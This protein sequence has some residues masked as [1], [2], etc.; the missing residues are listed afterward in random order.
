MGLGLR[1]W[2]WGC[3]ALGLFV[4]SLA[5][6]ALAAAEAEGN[7]WSRLFGLSNAQPP[8]AV[9]APGVAGASFGLG[10]DIFSERQ[11][12]LR[13]NFM[14]QGIRSRDLL[15]GAEQGEVV[16]TDPG[17]LNRK[18]NFRFDL[19]GA[20]VQP[21]AALRLPPALG[22]YPTLVLQAAAADVGLDFLDRNRPGDSSSLGGRGPLFGAGLDL[23]RALCQG[24]PWFA[25]ASYLFQRLPSLTVDRSPRFALPGFEV[26]DD[27][28][29]LGRDVQEASMRAGYG[30]PGS[31]VV[32]YLGVRHRWNDV[33]IEDHLR[34]RDPFQEVET[35]LA[36]RT[37]LKS[38][39]T[40]ALAGVEARLGPRL[41]GRLEA[42]AGGGDRGALLRVVYLGRNREQ[43][44]PPPRPDVYSQVVDLSLK[45]FWDLASLQVR[46]PS[47]AGRLLS[48]DPRD[49][50]KTLAGLNVGFE[51]Y[52]QQLSR[53]AKV[54]PVVLF[55]PHGADPDEEAR[56]RGFAISPWPEQTPP[57]FF[58]GP[59]VD[60]L[61]LFEPQTSARRELRQGDVTVRARIASAA[62]WTGLLLAQDA[63][64]KVGLRLYRVQPKE[65]KKAVV[66][67]HTRCMSSGPDTKLVTKLFYQGGVTE[68]QETSLTDKDWGPCT[69]SPD[70]KLR[71]ATVK[72]PSGKKAVRP[73]MIAGSYFL[74]PHPGP[75]LSDW[76]SVR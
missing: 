33:K 69:L 75:F 57:A 9:E 48:T 70:S 17:L 5:F 60:T 58:S 54:N 66:F 24:C 18:F 20:G 27:E 74:N 40:L 44:P 4:A 46:D 14:E 15:T 2:R 1:S 19:K 12:S 36:S 25:G 45:L 3:V 68:P 28:V 39:V 49:P 26:L 32:S 61:V 52:R 11:E 41:F 47:A 64:D 38:E 10:L 34:Y 6:P 50:A 8:W 63:A 56:R 16:R 65:W 35:A 7:L 59:E 37:Q 31:P 76:I 62:G 29:R 30:F 23:T 42:S 22:L 71:A 53:V 73:G 51:A 13:I 21:A 67:E 55:L 72:Q 43:P